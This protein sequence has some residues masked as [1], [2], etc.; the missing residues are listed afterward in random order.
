[1]PL[2][3]GAYHMIDRNEWEPQRT[4]N[5]EIIFPNLGQLYTI[6]QEIALPSNADEL[7]TLS[8]K[9][10]SYPS[11]NI[12]KLT[13]SYG[14][15]SIN[16]AGRPEYSDVTIIVNDFIGIQ[17]ER[18][19]MGWSKKVYDPKRETIGWASQYKRDGYLIEYSPDGTVARR[20]QLRGCFPGNV[21]PGDFS[22][23][24]NSLREISVTFYV[25]VAIPL[26]GDTTIRV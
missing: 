24:D 21:E 19:L 2:K 5:F 6:D 13:V 7:L 26:D 11:T 17:T 20:T 12:D 8:V 22:N 16:F 3:L 4:N 14:N 10:V 9:S 1:M 25:D 15:N 23:D 18:I